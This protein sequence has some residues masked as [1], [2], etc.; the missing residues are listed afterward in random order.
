[1]FQHGYW[2]TGHHLNILGGKE[3]KKRKNMVSVTSEFLEFV[4]FYVQN[5]SGIQF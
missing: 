2:S 3:D 4:Y 1:M 5:C